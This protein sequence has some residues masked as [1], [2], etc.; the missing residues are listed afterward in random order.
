MAERS[1]EMVIARVA[2][3]GEHPCAACGSVGA[4]ALVIYAAP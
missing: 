2:D 4:A 3:P 1:P